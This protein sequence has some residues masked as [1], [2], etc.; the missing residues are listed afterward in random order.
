ML[1]V[2]NQFLTEKLCLLRHSKESELSTHYNKSFALQQVF[3]S[4]W[5]SPIEVSSIM[6]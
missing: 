3:F 5:Q 4:V 1:L 6:M 2:G